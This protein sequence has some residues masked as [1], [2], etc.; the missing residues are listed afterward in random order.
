[1]V[2]DPAGWRRDVSPPKPHRSPSPTLG[3]SGR[4][5]PS[6]TT[7]KPGKPGVLAS[8]TDEQLSTLSRTEPHRTAP[9]RIESATHTLPIGECE[10]NLD[11]DLAAIIDAWDRL[12]AAVR[13]GI[14]A[15][16]KTAV[17]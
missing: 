16:V 5:G 10:C 7:R 14:V 4:I 2:S 15:M 6:G 12:P 11:P 9:G 13:A 3:A 8:S 1:M 17:R